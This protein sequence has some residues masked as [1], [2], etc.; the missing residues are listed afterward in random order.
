MYIEYNV[1]QNYEKTMTY[2]LVLIMNRSPYSSFLTVPN[3]FRLANNQTQ[4]SRSCR[5]LDEASV[6]KLADDAYVVAGR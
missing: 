5:L 3:A 6:D 2:D 1:S 4:V